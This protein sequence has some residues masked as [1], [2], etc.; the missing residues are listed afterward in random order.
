MEEG[1]SGGTRVGTLL[2][3]LR[4]F[5]LAVLLICVAMVILSSIGV[6]IGPLIA[7]AGIVGLA[8][9]FG[10]QTLVKDIISGLFFLLD[11]AFRVGDYV[12]TGAVKGSVEKISLRSLQLRHHRGMVHTI[13]FGGIS[14]VTNF[15]RDYIISK[16]DIRVRYDTDIEKVR[17]MIKKI[18]SEIMGDE[19]LASKLLDKIKSQGI[20]EMDD[21]AMIMRIKFKSIPGEQFQLRKEIYRRVQKAFGENDIAFAHRNVTVYLPDDQENQNVSR[22]LETGQLTALQQ[23]EKLINA[24]AAAIASEETRQKGDEAK[25]D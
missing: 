10:S 4:K 9:G 13:P 2:I 24:G 12:D 14:S 11:D 17:K 8:V 6:N 5:I 1:G 16:L 18:N 23:R 19:E 15:S 7:G 3:L 20:R 22:T 25:R 21:S